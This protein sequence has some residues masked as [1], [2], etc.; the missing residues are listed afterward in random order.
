[1]ETWGILYQL[2]CEKYS[3][4]F[5]AETLVVAYIDHTV[6]VEGLPRVSVSEVLVVNWDRESGGY[7][8]GESEGYNNEAMLEHIGRGGEGKKT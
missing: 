2:I 3:R 8:A 1:M 7:F 4:L 6:V 5:F